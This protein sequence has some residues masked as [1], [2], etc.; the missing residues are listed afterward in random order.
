MFQRFNFVMEFEQ[1]PL[2]GP[3]LIVI[4]HIWQLSVWFYERLKTCLCE[5]EMEEKYDEEEGPRIIVGNDHRLKT[6]L[7]HA[8]TNIVSH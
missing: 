1:K 5:Q 4:S 7:S 8:E 2:L 3:P 6:F